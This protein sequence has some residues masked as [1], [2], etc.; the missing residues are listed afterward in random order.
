[1]SREGREGESSTIRFGWN[2]IQSRCRARSQET[3]H[4]AKECQC[5]LVRPGFGFLMPYFG[6]IGIRASNRTASSARLPCRNARLYF[7]A[8]FVK[9]AWFMAAVEPLRWAVVSLKVSSAFLVMTREYSVFVVLKISCSARRNFPGVI[10]LVTEDVDSS[11]MI[12]SST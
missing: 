2:K 11:E 9:A 8:F 6:D 5:L 1:M 7:S 4:F 12:I 10:H 3:H